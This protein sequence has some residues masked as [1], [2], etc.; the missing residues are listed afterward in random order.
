M[1]VQLKKVDIF[2]VRTVEC[3]RFYKFVCCRSAL[4]D[5]KNHKSHDQQPGLADEITEEQKVQGCRVLS[6]LH[7]VIQDLVC[8]EVMHLLSAGLQH[9]ELWPSPWAR[10]RGVAAR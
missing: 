4:V 8:G 3:F 5:Q 1:D 10:A 7:R 6:G 9:A 2:V